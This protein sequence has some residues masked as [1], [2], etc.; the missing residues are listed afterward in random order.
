MISK[1]KKR[2][3]LVEDDAVLS[4]LT[5]MML[6]RM[7]YD[8]AGPVSTAI[9]AFRQ[10]VETVPDLV[11]MD[12]NLGT[13]FDGIDA[14]D[15]VYHFF[16]TP[17]VFLTGNTDFEVINRAKSADPFGYVVKPFT[18]DG[19]YATIEVAFN[20]Y[21]TTNPALQ[22]GKEKYLSLLNGDEGYI[23]VD[24]RGRVIFMNTYAEHLTGREYEGSFLKPLPDILQMQD[25]QASH[26]FSSPTYFQDLQHA[27]MLKEVHLVA[28]RS[29]A[30]KARNAKLSVRMVKDRT[31][32]VIGYV[33]R[34]EEVFGN[35]IV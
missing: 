12:I 35:G 30:G 4:G 9:G 14:A 26:H 29:S 31:G 21:C 22:K 8:V 2:I 11:L 17:V 27:A 16:Y 24:D 23:V 34:L 7:G 25:R 19:L 32:T 18:K 5:A 28:V 13:E 20:T 33:I 6:G 1:T 10:I 3:L 15:Y